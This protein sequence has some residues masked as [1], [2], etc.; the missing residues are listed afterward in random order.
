[1]VAYKNAAGVRLISRNGRDLT[2]RFRELAIAVAKP[3]AP[4]CHRRP[5]GVGSGA[6]SHLMPP[7]VS[8]HQGLVV[9]HKMGSIA[10]FELYALDRLRW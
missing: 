9:N 6:L 3:G 2:R 10:F 1:M 8:R 7:R 5:R 4:A